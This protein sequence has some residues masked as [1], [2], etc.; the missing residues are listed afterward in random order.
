MALGIHHLNKMLEFDKLLTKLEVGEGTISKATYNM[1][2]VRGT[3]GVLEWGDVAENRLATDYF[4]IE[5]SGSATN[6]PVK[7]GRIFSPTVLRFG[8]T[9]ATKVNVRYFSELMS[10]LDGENKEY[11]IGDFFGNKFDMRQVSQS[12][13]VS[14]GVPDTGLVT[15]S[16]A[17]GE[18]S[19]E[20]DYYSAIASNRTQHLEDYFVF[21]VRVDNGYANVYFI[22]RPQRIVNIAYG[23]GNNTN[24]IS[25]TYQAT[26]K[27]NEIAFDIDN[28]KTQVMNFT[29]KGTLTT[30]IIHRLNEG[31]I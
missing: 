23:I 26:N 16:I 5:I 1:S 13:Y 17:P 20:E 27:E 12:T 15:M 11:V 14:S 4:T 28:H 30:A 18:I 7:V 21:G 2:K 24:T 6:E 31:V 19:T 8:G 29:N 3:V 25:M 10:K 9:K 22:V